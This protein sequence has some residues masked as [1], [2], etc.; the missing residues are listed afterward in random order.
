VLSAF[1]TSRP[2]RRKQNRPPGQA[3]LAAATALRGE[4]PAA[5]GGMVIDLERYAQLA[6]VAR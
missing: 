2:C 4:Q 5:K 1:T 3:A 6:E